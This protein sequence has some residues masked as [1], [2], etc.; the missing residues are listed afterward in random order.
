[1]L[2]AWVMLSQAWVPSL[3]ADLREIFVYYPSSWP[4]GTRTCDGGPFLPL[5]R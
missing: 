2:E 4:F 3:G 1:M 5:A